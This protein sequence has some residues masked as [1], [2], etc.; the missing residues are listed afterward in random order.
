[1]RGELVR[2]GVRA[3]RAHCE[4]VKI[5]VRIGRVC[6][7]VFCVELSDGSLHRVA[8]RLELVDCLLAEFMTGGGGRLGILA[9]VTMNK[10]VCGVNISLVTVVDVFELI[11]VND[12]HALVGDAKISTFIF[13]DLVN[14]EPVRLVGVPV[15][16]ELNVFAVPGIF[17]G[18][19]LPGAIVFERF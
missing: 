8:H 5:V 12:F 3:Q 17:E 11:V 4:H 18:E 10:V 7:I 14:G 13:G 1:M 19:L 9:I 15:Q 16:G 2:A 6:T